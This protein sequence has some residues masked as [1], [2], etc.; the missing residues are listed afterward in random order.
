M[1]TYKVGD[2]LEATEPVIA[3]GCN[4]QGVMGSGVALAIRRKWPVVAQH[5]E[6]I[7]R[8]YGLKPGQV[9]LVGIAEGITVANCMTQEYYGGDG[10]QYVDYAAVRECFKY[11]ADKHVPRAGDGNA[12]AMPKIGAGLGGGD[13]EVIEKIIE[14]ELGHLGVTVYT[15]E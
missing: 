3:Q 8:N 14:E 5:Y 1:I 11:L 12:I 7:Y 9:I 15:L 13:W 4:C 10:R 2:L 6:L